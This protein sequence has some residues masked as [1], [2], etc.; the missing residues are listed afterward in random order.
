MHRL[1][2]ARVALALAVAPSL[3][4]AQSL[5]TSSAGFAS[6]TLVSLAGRGGGYN[7]TFGPV[8]LPGG[9][10]FTAD[11]QDGGISG[12]GSVL[13]D[14]CYGFSGATGN[15][16]WSCN[17]KILF[18][19]LDAF[20]GYMQFRFASP[21]NAVGAFVNYVPGTSP[22]LLSALDAA[23]NPF[24]TFDINALAPISTPGGDNAGG[25]RGIT[26]PSNDIYGIRFENRYIAATDI[27]LGGAA[28]AT[29]EPASL[30]LIASGV[31]AIVAV[32]RRRV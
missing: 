32:R 14:G 4:D 21:V 18:A 5:V 16:N 6:P 30:A 26:S 10:T 17:T 13:G 29:P 25:F 11:P 20:G 27:T 22:V 8:A 3:A 31:V 24:A 23:G 1:F 2:A 12:L 28:V 19:G 9:V 7:W 15:G